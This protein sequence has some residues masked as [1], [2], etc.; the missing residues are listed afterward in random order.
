MSL[1]LHAPSAFQLLLAA[2]VATFALSS[3]LAAAPE[4]A[5]HV[6]IPGEVLFRDDFSRPELGSKWTTNDAVKKAAGQS[7]VVDG[8]LVTKMAPHSDHGAVVSTAVQFTNAVLTCRFRLAD[9]KGFNLPIND[10]LND[11]VH[12]GHLCRLRITPGRVQVQDDASG[13]MNLAL[14]EQ[15]KDPAKAGAVAAQLSGKSAQF[16]APIELGKWHALRVEILGDELLVQIDGQNVA[17]LKSPGIAH[18]TKR[19][20]G[21][22]VP[23]TTGAAFDDVVLTTAKPAPTWPE[24]REATIAKLKPVAAAKKK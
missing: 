3:T 15:K 23:G 14:R 1:R 6:A 22:T 21:F 19:S 9:E 10:K 17:Y 20:F 18:P 8:T 5:S 2:V 24:A 13:T 11:Q 12:A 7:R 16:V 4:N